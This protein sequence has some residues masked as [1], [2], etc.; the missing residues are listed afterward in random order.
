MDFQ[1]ESEKIVKEF[2]PDYAWDNDYIS[3]KVA[4]TEA[5]RRA[6]EKGKWDGHHAGEA[7]GRK[8][9]VIPF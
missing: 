7:E 5:L 1:A 4:I 2:D 9:G 6:Y 8:Y 3:L